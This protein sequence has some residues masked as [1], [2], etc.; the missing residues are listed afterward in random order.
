MARGKLKQDVLVRRGRSQRIAIH[1]IENRIKVSN[2]PALL[3]IRARIRQGR[4]R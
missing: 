1:K 2:M 4:R 3:A